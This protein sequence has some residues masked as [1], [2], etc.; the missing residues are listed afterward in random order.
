MS[1]SLLGASPP[2]LHFLPFIP[3]C[4]VV[5]MNACGRLCV[6]SVCAWRFDLYLFSETEP[7]VLVILMFSVCFSV[8]HHK[9]A[10]SMRNEKNERRENSPWK[11][12][13][14]SFLTYCT[15]VIDP[16][17]GWYT[18]LWM[19]LPQRGD[20]KMPRRVEVEIKQDR[21]ADNHCY[22]HSDQMLAASVTV[23]NSVWVVS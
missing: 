15:D 21:G 20:L 13:L 12:L 11:S 3:F 17:K 9:H 23:N 22:D 14:N 8:F 18:Q 6:L 2:S 7:I 5:C 1:E 19:H 16:Q 10:S 4:T